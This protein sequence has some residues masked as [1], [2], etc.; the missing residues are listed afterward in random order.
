MRAQL[1]PLAAEAEV[2]IPDEADNSGAASCFAESWLQHLREQASSDSESEVGATSSDEEEDVVAAAVAA[3]GVPELGGCPRSAALE[4]ESFGS[5]LN[6]LKKNAMM[7]ASPNSKT[8]KVLEFRRLARSNDR[9]GKFIR[10]RAEPSKELDRREKEQCRD[11]HDA[12]R[13][14]ALRSLSARA[15]HTAAAE[16]KK[17]RPPPVREPAAPLTARPPA[18]RKGGK[19]RTPRGRSASVPSCGVVS[20]LPVPHLNTPRLGKGLSRRRKQAAL[21]A[22]SAHIVRCPQ[23]STHIAA[24]PMTDYVPPPPQ[25]S[26]SDPNSS[27]GEASPVFRKSLPEALLSRM[28]QRRPHMSDLPLVIMVLEGTAL[29]V[30]CTRSPYYA[31]G[32]ALVTPSLH[33]RPGL[34]E[35]LRSLCGAFQLVLATQLSRKPLLRL[36]KHLDSEGVRADAIYML[37]AAGAPSGWGHRAGG[38]AAACNTTQDFRAVYADFDIAPADVGRRVL[39]VSAINLDLNE[40]AEREGTRLLYTPSVSAPNFASRLPAPVDLSEQ[41]EATSPGPSVEAGEGGGE[42][43]AEGVV[44]VVLLV[45]NP[46]ASAEFRALPMPAVAAAVQALSGANSAAAAQARATNGSEPGGWLRGFDAIDAR[47]LVGRAAALDCPLKKVTAVRRC[48]RGEGAAASLGNDALHGCPWRLHAAG[49]DAVWSDAAAAEGSGSASVVYRVAV[50]LPPARGVGGLPVYEP[51]EAKAGS[52]TPR[53]KP[54]PACASQ[55][56]RAATGGGLP[57][58]MSA[59]ARAKSPPRPQ[60]YVLAR[61]ALPVPS[62]ALG[63]ADDGDSNAQKEQEKGDDNACGGFRTAKGTPRAPALSKREVNTPWGSSLTTRQGRATEGA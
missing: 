45:P 25:R 2:D 39:I 59:R 18:G 33:V 48:R 50:M 46:L 40:V 10:R 1:A 47:R 41:F 19:S 6:R 21:R 5:V 31:D 42:G 44:P 27:A 36:L 17:P 62:V 58:A 63:G 3:A 52:R 13:L 23:R 12:L 14:P 53:T 22:R 34:V 20:S 56:P 30:C 60:Q 61:E 38:N 55:T 15:E 9:A 24:M 57:K 29:D 32:G 37:P 35:G 8:T 7:E 28:A 4:D 51:L 11:R 26:L 43:E 16:E 54:L 49:D